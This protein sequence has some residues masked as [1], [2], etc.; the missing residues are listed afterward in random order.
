MNM[1]VSCL[2]IRGNAPFRCSA[3]S[4]FGLV[5]TTQNPSSSLK[6]ASIADG[7][8]IGSVLTLGVNCNTGDGA[9]GPCCNKGGEVGKTERREKKSRKEGGMNG[10]GIEGHA[11]IERLPR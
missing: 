5:C 6:D 11:L 2:V 4:T 3:H 1:N 9:K 10:Q 7:G 8:K